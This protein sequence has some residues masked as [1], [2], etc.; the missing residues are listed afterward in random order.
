MS[1]IAPRRKGW[2]PGALR[3]MATGDGLLVRVR[4]SG[5][6]LTLDQAGAIAAGA[7]VSGNGAISLSARGNLQV[8]GVSER[9]LPDLQARLAAVGL[10]DSDPEVERL[11]NILVS[12]LSDIDPEAAFDLAPHVAA[13]ESQLA[14]DAALRLLPSKFGFVLDADGRLPVG[15]IEADIRF[16]AA[17]EARGPAFAAYLAGDDA[18]AAISA[19][20]EIGAVASRL[21]RAFLALAGN[22]EA[23]RMRAVVGR[24]GAQAVFA[25]AGL[26]AR[27]RPRPRRSTA[28]RDVLGGHAFGSAILV[29]ASAPFGDIDAAGL[30]TL[31]DR[32]RAAGADSLRLAP[33]RSFLVTGLTARGAAS[34]VG[35]C[36]KLGFVV[37][38][39]DLRLRVVACPGAPPACTRSAPCARTLRAG[40]RCCRP[41]TMSFCTSV[42]ASRAAQGPT[43]RQRLWSRPKAAT[44]LSSAA[45]RPTGQRAAVSPMPRSTSS[46]P[47]KARTLRRQEAGSVSKRYTYEKDG[48][49]IY[50]QSFAIIRREADLARF[51]PVEERVA[52]RVVH[53]CGMVEAARDLI[54][55][56]GAVEAAKGALEAGAPIFCDA[57]MVAEG[58]TRA[59]LPANNDVICTLADPATPALAEKLGTTRTAAAIDLWLPRLAGS[60]VAIGN[61]PTALF[62]LLELIA[63]GAPAP[64]QSSACRSA[65]SAQRNRRRR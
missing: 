47:A 52:V 48:A 26:E 37:E 22:G 4:A 55:T 42:A 65:S 27:P 36:A 2:C 63:A 20:C 34:F 18:L 11:R 13:L 41:A 62:R 61:A 60:L 38:P 5:G 30:R 14:K 24:L 51:S 28:L 58:V 59:R 50:R 1:A 12:P 53:A 15:D 39:G 54:L 40:R 49:A 17:R 44:I 8:R 3:P 25:R 57:R 23:R 19:A 43:Q 10:L 31:I 32:A 56:P 64:P 29:G 6:R 45:G 33:W 35:A 9:T 46:W 21:A 7:L 16:E